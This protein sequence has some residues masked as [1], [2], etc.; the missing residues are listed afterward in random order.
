M[1]P[2]DPVTPGCPPEDWP[3]WFRKLAGHPPREKKPMDPHEPIPTPA[4]WFHSEVTG[5]C[6]CTTCTKD[7]DERADAIKMRQAESDEAT[8][9]YNLA[10]QEIQRLKDVHAKDRSSLL[11]EIRDLRQKLRDATARASFAQAINPDDL[12]DRLEQAWTQAIDKPTSQ[13]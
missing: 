8:Q 10:V 2:H 12:L 13:P 4:M 6:Q 1:S 3:D 7:R 11:N 9:A 5:L